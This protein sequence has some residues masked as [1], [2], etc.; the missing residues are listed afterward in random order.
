MEFHENLT[1]AN[2]NSEDYIQIENLKK[3]KKIML[4][5]QSFIFSSAQR[6][7]GELVSPCAPL[8]SMPSSLKQYDLSL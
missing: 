4:L 2:L 6:G 5:A 8:T 1:E 3:E 7:R